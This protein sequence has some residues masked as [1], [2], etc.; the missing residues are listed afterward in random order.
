[1]TKTPEYSFRYVDLFAGIGGFA[2]SMNSLG[3]EIH[4]AAEIDEL[5]AA[6]YELNLGHDPRRNVLDVANAA[7]KLGNYEV[8]TGGFPC[9]PFSKSG[10]QKGTSEARG[11][12]FGEIE[13][14]VTASKPL[15]IV[16]E[17][18]RNLV[19][20]RHKDEWNRI[21]GFLRSAGYRVSSIPAEFSPHLLPK[22]LGGRPHH[23]IRIFITATYNPGPRGINEEEPLP[24][25]TLKS[26]A[27]PKW[28]LEKDLPLDKKVSPSYKLTSQ[29]L[30]WLQAWD[31]VLAYWRSIYE[32]KFPGMPIWSDYWKSRKPSDFSEMPK[33]KQNFVVKNMNFYAEN[34]AFLD[35]WLNDWQVRDKFPASRRKFEWQ[36]GDLDSIFKG[37]IQLRPSGIR[38]KKPDY[39][40]TLV[41]LNQTPIYGPYKRRLTEIEVA[42]LQGFP[43]NWKP[44]ED[45]R[46]ATYKQ[47]GNAVH[48]GVIAH[49]F[50]EHCKRDRDI[51]Q[52]TAIGKKILSRVLTGPQNPDEIF[53][54]W[55]GIIRRPR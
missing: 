52:K 24:A 33:W 34:K 42:R 35:K 9:Q 8:L 41:A 26:G 28:R 47:M 49:V 48:I 4:L 54:Q 17:N 40:P 12:L 3:G 31:Q 13:K 32:S 51:L 50:R 6:T 45:N 2:A 7:S 1:M 20:P 29:E 22:E 23:R 27:M 30:E 53:E 37:L 21:I 11:T 55:G 46:A 19:G 36:A 10:A 14:I 16:L 15:V 25:V 44:N 39:V 18:V 43:R 38:V 5:A